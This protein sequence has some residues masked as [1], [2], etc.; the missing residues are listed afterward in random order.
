MVYGVVFFFGVLTDLL[1]YTPIG[2]MGGL[3]LFTVVLC[4]WQY[5]FILAQPYHGIWLFFTVYW[6][7]F[8]TVVILVQSIYAR[9]IFGLY[10]ELAVFLYGVFFFPVLWVLMQKAKVLFADSDTG[11]S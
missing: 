5:R 2:L 6:M 8:C 4:R 7:V 9:H 10:P 1:S 11:L 3:Y